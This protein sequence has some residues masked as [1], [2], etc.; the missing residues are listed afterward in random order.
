MRSFDYSK[1]SEKTWDNEIISYISTRTIKNCIVLIQKRLSLCA[2]LHPNM[3]SM[4]SFQTM[5]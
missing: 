3:N 1:L 5:K 2:L 4:I